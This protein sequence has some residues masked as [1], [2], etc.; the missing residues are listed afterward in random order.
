M[1]NYMGELFKVLI[2]KKNMDETDKNYFMKN[3]IIK[4]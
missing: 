3:D 4:L 1:P 2:M